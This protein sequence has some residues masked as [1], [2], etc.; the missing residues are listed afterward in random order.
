MSTAFLVDNILNDKDE[1]QDSLESDTDSEA[2]SDIKD[3]SQNDLIND[4]K[5]LSEDLLRRYQIIRQRNRCMGKEVFCAKCN[6]FQLKKQ[7]VSDVDMQ[8]ELKCEK[9]GSSDI[10]PSEETII[11]TSSKPILKFSVSAILGDKNDVVK[12]RNGEID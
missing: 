9:C 4:S 2:T 10:M 7:I 5:D 12:V 8:I 1:Q 11:N 6:C 3:Y